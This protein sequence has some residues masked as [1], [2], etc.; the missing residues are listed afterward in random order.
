MSRR[1][2]GLFVAFFQALDEPDENDE[3]EE[4]RDDEEDA[5]TGWGKG[6]LCALPSS[7]VPRRADR[8]ARCLA[9]RHSFVPGVPVVPVRQ[10]NVVALGVKG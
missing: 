8:F 3:D 1:R 10:R 5:R 7:K 9:R 2:R 6:A 4:P